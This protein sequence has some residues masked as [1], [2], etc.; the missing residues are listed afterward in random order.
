VILAVLRHNC[1][2]LPFVTL[3]VERWEDQKHALLENFRPRIC[4]DV[5]YHSDT[6]VLPPTEPSIHEH[7][8]ARFGTL[9]ESIKNFDIV[10]EDCSSLDFS[11]LAAGL[12]GFGEDDHWIALEERRNKDSSECNPGSCSRFVEL[13]VPSRNGI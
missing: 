2:H 12:N 8:R 13:T 4:S 7:S 9:D 1:C 11:W 3:F 10:K 6:A 5:V